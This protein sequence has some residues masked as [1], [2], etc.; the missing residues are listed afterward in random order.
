M[1]FFWGD[2]NIICI[3]LA[4]RWCGKEGVENYRE[5][6]TAGICWRLSGRIGFLVWSPGIVANQGPDLVAQQIMGFEV[7]LVAHGGNLF[8]PVA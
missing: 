2:R 8:Y 5:K 3:L 1:I 7:G 4:D 6:K